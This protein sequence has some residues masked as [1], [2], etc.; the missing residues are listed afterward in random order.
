MKPRKI[1]TLVRLVS[2]HR[3][4]R[5]MQPGDFRE[6]RASEGDSESAAPSEDWVL[7]LTGV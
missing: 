2:T 1:E 3:C 7:H 6:A 4:H 5:E